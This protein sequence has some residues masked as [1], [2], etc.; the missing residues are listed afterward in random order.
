MNAMNDNGIDNNNALDI[1]DEK[2][3]NQLQA[4]EYNNIE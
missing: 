2:F 1:H 4:I 3:I